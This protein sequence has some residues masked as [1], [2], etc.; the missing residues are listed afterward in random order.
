MDKNFD[1]CNEQKAFTAARN[2]A[3]LYDEEELYDSSEFD[4][5]MHEHQY[6]STLYNSLCTSCPYFCYGV[7]VEYDGSC[8]YSKE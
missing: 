6:N 5:D 3:D 4:D 2:T 8:D 7:C 1:D